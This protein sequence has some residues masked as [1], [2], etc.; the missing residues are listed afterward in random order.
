M[1]ICTARQVD[2]Q[3]GAIHGLAIVELFPDDANPARQHHSRFPLR[4]LDNFPKD[5]L[6]PHNPT[7]SLKLFPVLFDLF[8][9]IPIRRSRGL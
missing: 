9:F 1:L 3:E 6:E 5:G 8:R 2:F 7:I 4:D